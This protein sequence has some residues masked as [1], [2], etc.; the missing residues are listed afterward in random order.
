[1]PSVTKDFS[2]SDFQHFVKEV[3]GQSNDR[4]F[5]WDDV[6]FNVERFI[7]RAL[8]GIRKGD[9]DKTA[10]NL[11]VAQAWFMSLLN[12]LHIDLETEVWQ[13]FSGVCS[14]CGGCPCNCQTNKAES[15][16]VIKADETKRPKTIKDFQA[17]FQ[18][19]YPSSNRRLED[20]GIHLAEEVGELN[21]A[22][23]AYRG[24]HDDS[25]FM[26]VSLEAADLFSCLVGTFNS[27]NVDMADKLAKLFSDNCHIC[28]QA[29]CV[30]NFNDIIS[31]KS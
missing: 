7:M 24:S 23:M 29:P 14:Y 18:A 4:Y 26:A 17:M 10:I 20:A 25:S 16:L 13:R 1:M 8:K 30:C 5:N 12:Q 15:R 9:Q 19:I 11:L 22:L 31:F 3:Y 28:H 6:A 27:L 2:L 21:E